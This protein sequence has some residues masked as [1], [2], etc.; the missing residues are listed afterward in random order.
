MFLSE[1]VP[2]LTSKLHLRALHGEILITLSVTLDLLSYLLQTP[3][4]NCTSRWGLLCGHGVGHRRVVMDWPDTLS[5]SRG[6]QRGVVDDAMKR[7]S[8]RRVFSE[9]RRMVWQF[10][11]GK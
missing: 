10:Y 8:H 1:S 7:S 6:D 4:A 9:A 11:I 2:E 5:R 3:R